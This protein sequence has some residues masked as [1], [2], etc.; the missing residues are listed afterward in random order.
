V[1]TRPGARLRAVAARL[2]S[3]P[4]MERF[5]DPAVADLQHEHA[6]ACRRGHCWRAAGVRGV[7]TL[8]LLQVIALLGARRALQTGWDRMF[9]P[10][11]STPA[12]VAGVTAFG[13]LTMT[14]IGVLFANVP[15]DLIG[16]RGDIRFAFL[17]IPATF[18]VS[19]PCGFALAAMT[20]VGRSAGLRQRFV[21]L[22]TAAALSGL[23]FVVLAAVTPHAN[24]LFRVTIARHP[25]ARGLN[26]LT[27]DELRRLAH[28]NP[29]G[30]VPHDRPDWRDFIQPVDARA[31]LFAYYSRIS[32]PLA[33]LTLFLF[34]LALSNRR[35]ATRMVTVLFVWASYLFWFTWLR[36]PLVALAAAPPALLAWMPNILVL[37]PTSLLAIGRFM[38]TSASSSTGM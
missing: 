15:F 29:V 4:A 2:L 10:V 1:T 11:R 25:L 21:L 23:S 3:E 9:Q 18:V 7:G 35:R 36:D 24:Q 12:I 13:V 37:V 14:L 33:P 5:V 22:V 26:E 38:S 20:A 8:R 34:A 19:I 30:I 28:G 32:L 17:L 27:F 16:H 6:Q 31:V